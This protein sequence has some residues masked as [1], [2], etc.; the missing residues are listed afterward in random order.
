MT[1]ASNS[2]TSSS[3]SEKRKKKAQQYQNNHYGLAPQPQPDYGKVVLGRD[4]ELMNSAV[5][6][7]VG[8]PLAD[9]GHYDAVGSPLVDAEA[10]YASPPIKAASATAASATQDTEYARPPAPHRIRGS[11]ALA[12]LEEERN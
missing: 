1:Q 5:Y 10:I 11:T 4:S 3:N 6:E 9:G 2:T 8:A 7:G 12:P